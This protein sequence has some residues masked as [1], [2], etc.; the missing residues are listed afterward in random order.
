MEKPKYAGVLGAPDEHSSLVTRMCSEHGPDPVFGS[1]DFCFECIGG[2]S[3]VESLPDVEAAGAKNPVNK[4]RKHWKPLP[5]YKK[6]LVDHKCRG[7]FPV[8]YENKRGLM[9]LKDLSENKFGDMY[10]FDK[11][12]YFCGDTAGIVTCR[13]H[14]DFV[15]TPRRFK[16]TGC[17]ECAKELRLCKKLNGR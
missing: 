14:G 6:P 5:V 7:C 11:F 12:L 3:D 13:Y 8:K 17:Y 16:A 15:T 1:V 10:S 9:R 2:L 4:S